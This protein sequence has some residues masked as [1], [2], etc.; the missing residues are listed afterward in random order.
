MQHGSAKFGYTYIDKRQK[1]RGS[2]GDRSSEGTVV[3]DV[4]G[5]RLKGMS[6]YGIAKRLNET[7]V[8]SAGYNGKPGGSWSSTTVRQMLKSPTYCGKSARYRSPVPGHH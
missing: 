6:M 4:L 8:K 7:G 3:Q 5:W 2:A 1:G